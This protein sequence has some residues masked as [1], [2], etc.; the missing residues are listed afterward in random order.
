MG[1]LRGNL[2][3]DAKATYFT[4]GLDKQ[5]G[6]HPYQTLTVLS[7]PHAIS[8]FFSFFSHKT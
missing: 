8:Y 6:A 4:N 5:H 2:L 3:S 1:I 7:V